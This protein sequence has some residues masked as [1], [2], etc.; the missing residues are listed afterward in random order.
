M[1]RSHSSLSYR[2]VPEEREV[3]PNVCAQAPSPD[4]GS[5]DLVTAAATLRP[6]VLVPSPLGVLVASPSPAV[7][8]A[9]AEAYSFL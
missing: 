4:R 7:L 5:S 6:C 2:F 8:S 3:N 1:L 9:L